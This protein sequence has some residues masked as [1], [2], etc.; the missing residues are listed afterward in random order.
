MQRTLLWKSSL[1]NIGEI[2]SHTKV[3]CTAFK[4]LQFGFVIFR[5]KEFGAKAAHKML[6]KSTPWLN[7]INIFWHLCCAAFSQIIFDYLNGNSIWQKC[8]KNG[9]WHKSHHLEHAVKFQQNCWWNR[10]TSSVSITACWRL[11]IL[12]KL[13]GE[14]DFMCLCQN[15]FSLLM[16][17]S[18]KLEGSFQEVLF[19]P[20][21]IIIVW[22][23]PSP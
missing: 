5:Q 12:H 13:V 15:L 10:T 22:S 21:L 14:I 23:Y 1:W 2:D 20:S 6:V 16:I 17:S 9:A 3:L 19:Q 11:G 18:N 7:F 8:T 4:C